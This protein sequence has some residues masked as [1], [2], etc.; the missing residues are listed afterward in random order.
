MTTRPDLPG[1]PDSQ[2]A[3]DDDAAFDELARRAGAALR[4]PAPEDG[5][6]VIAHR[7]R[8]RQVLKVSAV[9]GSAVVATLLA[10]VVV[11]QRDDPDRVTAGEA[12]RAGSRSPSAG[13]TVAVDSVQGSRREPT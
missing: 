3:R 1:L 8:R 6:R 11:S 10:L 4:R 5:V 12:V 2:L 9:G 13:A 7:H